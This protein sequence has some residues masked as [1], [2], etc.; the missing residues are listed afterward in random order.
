MFFIRIKVLMLSNLISRILCVCIF[1]SVFAQTHECSTALINWQ[2][3]NYLE[4]K[5]LG[6]S[7]TRVSLSHNA[8]QRQM[9]EYNQP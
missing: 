5:N 7:E 2:I 9:C 3:P 6:E 4:A 8:T 1:V